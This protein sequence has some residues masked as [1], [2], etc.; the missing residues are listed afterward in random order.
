MKA[1]PSFNCVKSENSIKK[2]QATIE[3]KYPAN[4][5]LSIDRHERRQNRKSLKN[6]RRRDAVFFVDLH[7]TSDYNDYFG[8]CVAP[9]T[10]LNV[11]GP[12]ANL[13]F[14]VKAIPEETESGIR[15][16]SLFEMVSY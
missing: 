10:S 2:E 14:S 16:V 12:L 5:D 15:K 9:G 8:D 13:H 11:K 3:S 6:E 4:I 7:G 1:F